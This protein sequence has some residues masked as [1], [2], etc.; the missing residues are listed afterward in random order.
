MLAFVF[1][2]DVFYGI[3]VFHYGVLFACVVFLCLFDYF[4]YVVFSDLFLFLCCVCVAVVCLCVASLWLFVF[5][6]FF[7]I[8]KP[9]SSW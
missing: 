6:S 9:N 3:C 1:L 7:I 8:M 4:V 5:V 2:V